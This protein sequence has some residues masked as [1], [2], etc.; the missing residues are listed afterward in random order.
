MKD[1]GIISTGDLLSSRRRQCTLHAPREE[2][3][4]GKGSL[5]IGQ[6]AKIPHAEREEY[7]DTLTL[8]VNPYTSRDSDAS[9]R[10]EPGILNR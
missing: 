10:P 1:L 9:I 6:E 3:A 8:R 2:S 7:T 4:T 5:P